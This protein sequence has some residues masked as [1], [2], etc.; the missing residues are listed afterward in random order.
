MLDADIIPMASIT[1]NGLVVLTRPIG[2]YN[3]CV[4]ELSLC[5]SRFCRI[6]DRTAMAITF[7]QFHGCWK[8]K[9][10]LIVVLN[11]LSWINCVS[12]CIYL[13]YLS[14][15]FAFVCIICLYC[16]FKSCILTHICIAFAYIINIY[17]LLVLYISII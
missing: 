4:I 9:F 2:N 3:F 14:A 10:E 11:G 5:A 16:L 17:H 6:Y 12:M 8:L 7:K 15:C 13:N 1:F